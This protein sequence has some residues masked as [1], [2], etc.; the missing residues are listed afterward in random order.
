MSGEKKS[1]LLKG[2]AGNERGRLYPGA[3]TAT[4]WTLSAE[5]DKGSLLPISRPAFQERLGGGKKRNSH[6]QRH[7]CCDRRALEQGLRVWM[8]Q[9]HTAWV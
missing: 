1:L 5:Q 8:L 3:V 6:T 9:P 7:G 4:C 2:E